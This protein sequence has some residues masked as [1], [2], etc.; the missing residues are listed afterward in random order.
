MKRKHFNLLLAAAVLGLAA[1][2]YFSQKKPEAPP[3]PLTALKSDDIQR[4]RVSHTGHPEIRLEKRKDEWWLVAPV[5]TRAEAVEVAGIL[6]L[7]SR[8]SQR[9]YAA[10]EMNL[11][12]LGLAEPRWRVQL[13][14][15]AIAFGETDPIE[16]YR[17]VQVADQ[18]H[19]IEDPPSAALDANYT[20]LVSRRLLPAQAQLTR[21]ELP[22]LT[23]QRS[24][25]QGWTV[26]PASA[27]TSAD[28]AQKL[29]D[30][31]RNAQA[32]WITP[33][34]KKRSLGS[35]VV[36]A[37][38]K[39]FRFEILDRDDQLIL[40]RPELGVQFTLSKTLA[41]DLFA[42]QPKPSSDK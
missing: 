26:T 20:D 41:T 36:K 25:K 22:G 32:M 15:V 31:W 16:S 34:D 3:P 35:V 5:E 42:L 29:A 24:D 19:L 39:S 18:V 27:D 8:P 33:R 40:A 21:I 14:D 1:A 11:A 6:D 4:L 7:A 37:G 17:Y 10:A 38:T 28:A 12:E 2:V 13:N 30:A 9:R 23:L